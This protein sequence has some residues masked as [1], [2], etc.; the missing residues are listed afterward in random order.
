MV[1][2]DAATSGRRYRARGALRTWLRNAAALI[3]W[4]VGVDRERLA[5]WYRT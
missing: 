5:R 1:S 4:R 2:L 3:A